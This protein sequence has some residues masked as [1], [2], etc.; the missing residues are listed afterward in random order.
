MAMLDPSTSY[1]GERRGYEE[2]KIQT[3]TRRVRNEILRHMTVSVSSTASRFVLSY[4][5]LPK[6]CLDL[7]ETAHTKKL[8]SQP[9]CFLLL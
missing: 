2:H 1:I 7:S 6:S 9:K 3:Q 8:T 4:L 5:A